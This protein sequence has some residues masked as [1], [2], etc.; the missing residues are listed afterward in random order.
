MQYFAESY[1]P[2]W[3][4]ERHA[5][6]GV[7]EVYKIPD[8]LFHAI[9]Q[10][11]RL[12]WGSAL[13]GGAFLYGILFGIVRRAALL[14]HQQ[15]AQLVTAETMAALGEMASAVA[16]NLRNPLASIRSSA[17]V[18]AEEEDSCLRRQNTEDIIMVVDRLEGWIRELL[19]YA[20]PLHHAPTPIQLHMVLQQALQPFDKDLEQHNIT[21]T[22]EVPATLPPMLADAHLLQHAVHSL[23]SNAIEAMPHG[24]TL[25]ITARLTPDRHQVDVCICDTGSGIAAEQITKVFRPFFTTKRKGLGIGLSLARRIIERHGGTITLSS[26]VDRG[27]TVTLR[28]PVTE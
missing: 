19:T 14:I 5:V 13:I 15:Q 10:G 11:H 1:L 24:G 8:A 7:V 9:H 21:L 20:R 4:N 25:T 16:H 17:E 12:V 3:N 18:A 22:L 2:I 23:I 26:T 6:M 28:L 27:T